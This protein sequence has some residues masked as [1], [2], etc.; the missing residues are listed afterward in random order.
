MTNIRIKVQLE[1]DTTKDTISKLNW[2][3]RSRNIPYNTELRVHKITKLDFTL[4]KLH[5]VSDFAIAF[6]DT[7]V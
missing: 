7:F 4:H 6:G 5:D 2:W 3:L 1:V